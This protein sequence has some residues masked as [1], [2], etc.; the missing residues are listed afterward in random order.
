MNISFNS[1]DAIR[2]VLK[3]EIEKADYTERLEKSLRGFRSTTTMPGFRKGMAPLGVIKKLYGKKLLFDELNEITKETL[4]VYFEENPDI[5]ILGHALIKSIKGRNSEEGDIEVDEDVDILLDMAFVPKVDV[6][7]TSED[8]LPYYSIVVD[9]SL[10]DNQID[11]YRKSIPSYDATAEEATADSILRGR[12][13]ELD[14]NGQPK[15]NGIT[16]EN[17]TLLLQFIKNPA[18]QGKILGAKKGSTIIFNPRNA[19]EG[20]TSVDAE[21]ASLLERTKKEIADLQ[22]DFSFEISKISVRK[23]AEL[24]QEFY[25]KILGEGQV[26]N[27]EDFRKAM[28]AGL[29]N[30]FTSQSN[31]RFLKDLR[32]YI[33]KKAGEMPIADE[34]IKDLFNFKNEDENG[35]KINEEDINSVYEQWANDMRYD[36]VAN[37][38]LE[39]YDIKVTQEDLQQTALREAQVLFSQYGIYIADA[40]SKDM[41]IGQFADKIMSDKRQYDLVAETTR[42]EKLILFAKRTATIDTRPVSLKDFNSLPDPYSEAKPAEAIESNPAQEQAE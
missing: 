32:V 10:V 37:H 14:E 12:M 36:L 4:A 33:L 38:I 17:A 27:E 6:E 24:N 35:M 19:Y 25:D 34:I 30:N 23:G 39:R 22:S 2:G 15:E 1:R 29:D 31:L 16:V 26:T 3:L 40:A 11:M 9:D 5:N 13:V 41:I 18:E 42:N 20:M 21:I 8:I 28:K 7:L